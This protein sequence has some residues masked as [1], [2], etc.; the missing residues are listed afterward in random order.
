MGKQAVS[1]L[2][3]AL[4]GY[5]GYEYLGYAEGGQLTES[6]RRHPYAV[7]ILDLAWLAGMGSDPV[8]QFSRSSAP[9]NGN[10]NSL[11]QRAFWPAN[12]LEGTRSQWKLAKVHRGWENARC[13][14]ASAIQPSIRYSS[15]GEFSGWTSR[16]S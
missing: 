12:S 7:E 9:S 2:I 10:C 5:V 3:G 11:L 8:H 14:S 1:R 6:L 15:S 4:P 13:A 16:R